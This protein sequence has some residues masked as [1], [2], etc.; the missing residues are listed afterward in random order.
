MPPQAENGSEKPN[1][2]L[3][4]L[5][6][7]YILL[8]E[9]GRGGAA[10]VYKSWQLGMERMVA[11]KMILAGRNA[12][13]DIVDRFQA[14]ARAVGLELRETTL[15]LFG[16]PA[17]GTGVMEASPLAAL[18]LPLKVL[19]REDAEGKVWIS[20]NTAAYLQTRHG[21]PPDLVRNIAVVDALATKAA[22]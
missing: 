9:L 21:L 1:A 6:P 8:Q 22:E 15:V 19:V 5:P 2:K 7:G 17:A 10:V 12:D 14:E 3:L 20:Y 4:A 16:N 18:D 13:H 11:L